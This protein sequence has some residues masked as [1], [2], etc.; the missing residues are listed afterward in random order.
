MSADQSKPVESRE[1]SRLSNFEVGQRVR[2]T[3]S[4]P[5]LTGTMENRVEGVI[6]RLGQQK[7]GSWYAH[8]KNDKL[9]LDRLELRT[10]DGER[11]VMNVDQY[12]LIEGL[13]P[14]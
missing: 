14:A 9:W 10:S 2:V 4:V 12:T 7:T 11:V 5:R 3:Q 1:S 8:G 13:S 6:M